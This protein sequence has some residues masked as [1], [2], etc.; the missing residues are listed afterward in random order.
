MLVFNTTLYY[1]IFKLFQLWLSWEAVTYDM[2]RE[3]KYPQP[4]V[5]V[6]EWA[7][8]LQERA[9]HNPSSS[10]WKNESGF[11]WF[12][13]DSEEVTKHMKMESHLDERCSNTSVCDC[14]R[15]ER[16]SQV[17]VFQ[18]LKETVRAPEMVL[19][20]ITWFGWAKSLWSETVLNVKKK[21]TLLFYITTAIPKGF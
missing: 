6:T 20:R 3:L 14:K 18:N 15:G 10:S 13:P 4:S 12:R 5:S 2:M 7:K 17:A 9:G 8:N 1:T 11:C 19:Q 16:N 21:I